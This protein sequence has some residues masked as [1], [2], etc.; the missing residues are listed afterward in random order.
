MVVNIFLVKFELDSNG[1]YIDGMSD[2][3]ESVSVPSDIFHSLV[4]TT[5]GV[6][7][8]KLEVFQDESRSASF[9]IRC[10]LP[11]DVFKLR[12]RLREVFLDKLRNS[13]AEIGTASVD[14][15]DAR[16]LEAILGLFKVLTSLDDL[17][18]RKLKGFLADD[19]MVVRVD[20]NE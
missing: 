6:T 4:T 11:G 12:G 3:I 5:D 9:E 18:T 14:E 7:L 20:T 17:L 13:V 1:A 10:Y 16:L 2:L 8:S 19:S 15:L